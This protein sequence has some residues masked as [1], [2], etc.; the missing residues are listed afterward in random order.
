MGWGRKSWSL[1]LA[2]LKKFNRDGCLTA[3]AYLSYV[4]LLALVPLTIVIL[5]LFTSFSSLANVERGMFEVLL[6]YLVPSSA[7]EVISYIKKFS[8]NSKAI[9]I[10]GVMGLISLSYALFEAS[11]K[12]F[13]NIWQSTRTRSFLNRV[14]TFSNILFW[15]P[16]LLGM[17]F[18]I[19]TKISRLPYL[20]AFSKLLLTPLPLLISALAFSLSYLIIPASR[21]EARAAFIGGTV[22]AIFW[23]FAKHAFDLY[24]K[25]ALS[26]KAFTAL[27]GPLILFPTI[28]VW[29]YLSWNITLLGAEVSYCIQYG[30][31]AWEEK[32]EKLADF[33]ASLS[34]LEKVYKRF[35]KG[36][37]PTHEE[38]IYMDTGINRKVITESLLFLE[39]KGIVIPTEDGFLP[40]LPPEKVDLETLFRDFTSQWAVD[41]VR[42]IVEGMLTSIRGKTLKD[43]LK[44]KNPVGGSG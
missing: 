29:I 3:S 25:V 40:A 36:E 2:C 42:T 18:Y 34:I 8:E 4:S 19:T 22:A 10:G 7:E 12:V 43:I 39:K 15:L 31:T 35:L 33:L 23:E 17:S 32:E 21:V 38:E 13:N 20:G 37:G 1:A 30:D 24:T 26:F 14:L 5:S 41:G 9:G 16:F 27:Y 11:E 6:K 44:D 28:M